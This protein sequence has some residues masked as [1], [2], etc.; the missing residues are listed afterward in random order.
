MMKYFL[1]ALALL[2]SLSGCIPAAVVAGATAGGAVVYDQRP[3]RTQIRDRNIAQVA[4]NRIH[5]NPDLSKA[6]IEIAAFNGV[7]LMVGQAPSKEI[8]DTAYQLVS[9][10]PYV[11]R[12]Y[13]EVEISGT[14]GTLNRADDD[15]I[16]TKVRTALLAEKGLNSAEIKVVTESGV[17]YLMGLVSPTQGD[18]AAS[19]AS[20]ITGVRKVVKVFEY[21]T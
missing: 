17:V 11:K 1:T 12:V 10:I 2:V 21:L 15:W 8:S 14:S 6:H 13:N 4:K 20:R 3:V 19:V 18:K 7:V 16:T 9:T 5:A